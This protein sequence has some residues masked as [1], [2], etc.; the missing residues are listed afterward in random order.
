VLYLR[1][2]QLA[3]VSSATGVSGGKYFSGGVLL[4]NR[5]VCLLDLA[6]ILDEGNLVVDEAV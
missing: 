6:K 4:D 2:A 1:A 3:D 5:V